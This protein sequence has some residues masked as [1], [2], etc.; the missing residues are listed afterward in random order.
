MSEL[1]ELSGRQRRQLRGLAHG[2]D[3]VV[4]VGKG[5]LSAEAVGQVDRALDDHELI[6]V[7]FVA[8]KEAKRELAAELAERTRSALAGTVGHVAILYR[9]QADPGKRRIR[10]DQSERPDRVI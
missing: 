1:S 10:L 9:P 6:K 3:P 7:R 8:D 2:L 4:H 5:G